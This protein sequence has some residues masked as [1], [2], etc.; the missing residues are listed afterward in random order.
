ML[1]ALSFTLLRFPVA[2]A[3]SG[4]QPAW[5]V[6]SW[7][8]ANASDPAA[9][10]EMLGAVLSLGIREIYQE[11]D[12]AAA[13]GFLRRAGELGLDVYLLAGRP[14]WG[15]QRNG[16]NMM[17]QVDRVAE[18]AAGM[19]Q[20]APKGLVLDVE[21]YL[22]DEYRKRPKPAMSRFLDALR[23]T[24]AHAQ[25]KGVRLIVCIPYF[26]DENGFED[27]LSGIITQASDGVAIMN[28]KKTDEPGQVEYELELA[29]QAGK[30]VIHIFELQPP[31]THD[32]TERNTY[33]GDGLGAV[34]DSAARLQSRFAYERLDFALHEL[35]SLQ[36]LLKGE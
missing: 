25:A 8:Q 5:G 20:S 23:K 9:R 18:L 3:L 4:T 27:I 32:L 31:G 30:R 19:G 6:F 11:M 12:S 35:S 34:W 28:Y 26:Y 21:P 24:Y 33:Y 13:P 36:E 1:L 17:A 15:L 22:T 29:R 16:K 10:E 2:K 7:N 14:E